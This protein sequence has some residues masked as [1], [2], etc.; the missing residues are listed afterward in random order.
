MCN[1]YKNFYYKEISRTSVS[2]TFIINYYPDCY[3]SDAEP[4]SKVLWQYNQTDNK[5]TC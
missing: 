4:C 5:L 3:Y 2:V 1:Y